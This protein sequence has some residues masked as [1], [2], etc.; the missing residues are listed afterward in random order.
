MKRRSMRMACLCLLL[1]SGQ[2]G[3]ATGVQLA[4]HPTLLPV[5]SG[6]LT[7]WGVAD[8]LLMKDCSRAFLAIYFLSGACSLPFWLSLARGL[9]KSA[10]WAI[11]TLVAVV[12]FIWATQLG[13]GDWLAYGIICLLSGAALG[14]DLALPAAV[15]AD[16]IPPRE[17]GRAASYFGI[18]SLINKGALDETFTYRDGS[19][20]RRV[21]YLNYL[22][23]GVLLNR[24]VMRKFGF[25][26]GEVTLFFQ[27]REP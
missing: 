14:A 15:A 11:G 6:T 4:E 23:D 12:G 7:W 5:G 20:Q 24:S 8:V 2:P 1:I 25:R 9:G 22:G 10:T 21:W 19:T 18:W 27:R 16:N 13:S 17:W 3:H 26:L